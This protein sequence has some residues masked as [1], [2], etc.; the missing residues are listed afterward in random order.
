MRR[1]GPLVV[2]FI[3][4]VIFFVQNFIPHPF[5][6]DA[7]QL[8]SK[9]SIVMGTFALA[10][11]IWTFVHL[12]MSKIK[13][14][15]EGWYFSV[16]ALAGMVGTAVIG[17]FGN[18]SSGTMFDKIFMFVQSPM[19]GTMFSLLAFFMASAA[20]RAFRA[21]SFEATLLLVA[22]IV[23]ML[24]RVPIGDLISGGATS[25]I[26]EYLFSV[27]NMAAKRAIMLGVSLGVIATS[28]KIIF[29]IERSWLGGGD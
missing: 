16:V 7:L 5:S 6:E 17:I 9:H 8:I 22:A 4:A 2:C 15:S 24:G 18:I 27:P 25:K 12:H 1:T 3:F 10:I 26:T 29:G 23:V 11:G 21:R 13:R 14:N 19:Q 28:L 20:Y